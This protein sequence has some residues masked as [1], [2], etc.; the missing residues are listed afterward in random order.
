MTMKVASH[1]RSRHT[2]ICHK[3]SV[4]TAAAGIVVRSSWG[5]LIVVTET[6]G[7]GQGCLFL[8]AAGETSVYLVLTDCHSDDAKVTRT[9]RFRDSGKYPAW[10]AS[11]VKVSRDNI[12]PA[13][14]YGESL[15][16]S[17]YS[18]R[19]GG[20]LFKWSPWEDYGSGGEASQLF[21]ICFHWF[22]GIMGIIVP[23]MSVWGYNNNDMKTWR[24]FFCSLFT[25]IHT[26]N[27]EIFINS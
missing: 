6:G 5:Q 17:W 8:R 4:I 18:V 2:H 13:S 7:R 10:M 20:F 12:N 9:G 26:N 22:E 16:N 24:G 3:D 19:L 14:Q 27:G 11:Y 15:G 21:D 1:V 25:N 23:E